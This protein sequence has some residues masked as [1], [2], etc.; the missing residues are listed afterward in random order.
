[1][2]HCLQKSLVKKSVLILLI[3]LVFSIPQLPAQSAPETASI[4]PEVSKIEQ[5][6]I[7][8]SPKGKAPRQSAP[9]HTPD[10]YLDESGF[11]TGNAQPGL[12]LDYMAMHQ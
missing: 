9:H 8:G 2:L 6:Y 1:M 4:R 5:F 7:G 10:F 3:A 12:A 11:A